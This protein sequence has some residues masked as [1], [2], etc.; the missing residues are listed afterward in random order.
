MI[1]YGLL[2]GII[3]MIF[4]AM[5]LVALCTNSLAKGIQLMINQNDDM[6]KLTM[7]ANDQR[8]AID[9]TGSDS[10]KVL[11]EIERNSRP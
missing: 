3:F 10:F 2:G 8:Q 9:N 5:V 1:I 4:N 7:D 11:E 6:L